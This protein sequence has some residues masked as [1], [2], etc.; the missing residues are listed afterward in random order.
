MDESLTGKIAIVT[1]ASSGIGEAT[2]VA[3]AARGAKLGIIARRKDRLESL[4]SR[5]RQ[6]SDVLVLEAD[7]SDHLQAKAAIE[8]VIQHFGR[9]DILVN[10]AGIM[11]LGPFEEVDILEWQKMVNVNLLGVMYCTHATIPIMKKQ[12]S[13]HIVNISSVAGRITK[14]NSAVYNAT[15]WGLGAFSDAIRQALHKDKIRVTIIEPGA[16]STELTEHIPHEK[17]KQQVQD[18]VGSIEALEPD[19]I[20]NSIIY[21]VTQPLRV[22]VNEILVRPT[23][24]PQ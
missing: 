13:G 23:E 12:Q 18:F 6:E 16:V 3:L 14:P 4:K 15:K 7:V 21:A 19:D 5:I 17:T 20:A 1:G 24:Q 2:A 10:N 9:V 22:N 11:L 8:Q